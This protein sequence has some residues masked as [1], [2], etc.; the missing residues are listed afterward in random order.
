M[1]FTRG[2]EGAT[3]FGRG[4]SVTRPARAVSVADTV[5]AGDSTMGGLLAALSDRDAL[6]RGR[7]A[8]LPETD[9]AAILDF[10]LAVAAVTCSRVGADPPRRADLE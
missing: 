8:R 4:G 7:L 3:I 6:D 5:G 2:G 10:A 9:L 1:L